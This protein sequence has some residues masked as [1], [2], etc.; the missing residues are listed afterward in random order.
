MFYKN[1]VDKI[2]DWYDF[3]V[4]SMAYKSIERMIYKNPGYAYLF[5]LFLDKWIKNNP[6]SENV[7]VATEI[8]FRNVVEK[9]NVKTN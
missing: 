9:N 4:Y 7:V 5:Y 6:P 2:V 1:L 3:K 8:F